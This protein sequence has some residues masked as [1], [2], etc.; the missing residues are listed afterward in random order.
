MHRKVFSII[1]SNW[2]NADQNHKTELGGVAGFHPRLDYR[3]VW[4][5]T[6]RKSPTSAFWLLGL[7]V[8]FTHTYW[9]IFLTGM[10]QMTSFHRRLLDW[11]EEGDTS[12]EHLPSLPE[13]AAWM[14]TSG[15][16]WTMCELWTKITFFFFPLRC[17]VGV[18]FFFIIATKTELRQGHMLVISTLKRQTWEGEEFK[19]IWGYRSPSELEWAQGYELYDALSENPSNQN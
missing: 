14:A 7:K 18:F 9:G 15:T 6:Q 13:E 12:A 10:P 17:F 3:V 8:C 5:N 16:W 1:L 4:P 11:R 19:V 2:E